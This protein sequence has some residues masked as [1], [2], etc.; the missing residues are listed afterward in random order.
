MWKVAKRGYKLGVMITKCARQ[1]S[2]ITVDP[3]TEWEASAKKVDIS[4]CLELM[5]GK[6]KKE[7]I[8]GVMKM[9]LEAPCDVMRI[10]IYQNFRDQ[11]NETVGTGF[12]FSTSEN[13]NSVNLE[14]SLEKTRYSKDFCPLVMDNKTMVSTNR[15]TIVKDTNI[16]K[17]LP[18]LQVPIYVEGSSIVAIQDETKKKKKSEDED[19]GIEEKKEGEG[20]GKGRNKK[21]KN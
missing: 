9:D 10:Y 19:E 18:D 6:T 1:Y 4:V 12:C 8:L 5:K 11:L 16:T 20:K 14:V 13:D 2:K 3:F 17:P 15:C 7:T 21:K